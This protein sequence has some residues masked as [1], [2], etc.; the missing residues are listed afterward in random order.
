MKLKVLPRKTLP[1]SFDERIE[2]INQLVREWINY[3][4][5]GSIQQK[6]KKLEEWLRNRLRYCI[7]HD[8]KNPDRKRKNFIRLGI[9]QNMAYAW[10]RTR[11]GGGSVAQSPILRTTITVARMIKG[12]YVSLVEYYKRL[13]VIIE[14]P[15]T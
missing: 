13:R 3:F 14:P 2:R 12:R 5:L 8:W 9:D 7:W 15:S 11:M 4:K 1:A 10:S 6:L